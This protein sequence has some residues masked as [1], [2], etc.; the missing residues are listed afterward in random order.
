MVKPTI[1]SWKMFEAK[2]TTLVFTKPWKGRFF[3][4][5]SIMLRTFDWKRFGFV[6][7]SI[8]QWLFLAMHCTCVKQTF[9]SLAQQWTYIAGEIWIN[10]FASLSH[11]VSTS[12]VMYPSLFP[13][14]LSGGT[15]T[16]DRQ[17]E[18]AATGTGMTGIESGVE[19]KPSRWL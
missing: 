14:W 13:Q 11:V 6:T 9:L 7:S 19:K 18:A 15:D 5:F 17:V 2:H 1:V 4:Q 10:E 12:N 16:L 8:H 3:Q